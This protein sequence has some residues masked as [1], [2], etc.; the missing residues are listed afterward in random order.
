METTASGK[1]S[2][3]ELLEGT[4]ENPVYTL[5][6]LLFG[7]ILAGAVGLVLI[8]TVFHGGAFMVLGWAA[9]ILAA[10]IMAVHM[11][12]NISRAVDY[13]EGDAQISMRNG[14]LIRYGVALVLMLLVFY[15]GKADPVAYVI[16]MLMLK[17]GAYMQPF[18]HFL[19]G[20]L[21]KRPGNEG[22]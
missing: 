11:Y 2:T 6:E 21:W 5:L 8:L 10:L 3:E 22:K 9:G 13:S 19:L 12:R 20:P 17:A 4:G 1:E 7:I 16:G 18:S 14:A 15:S